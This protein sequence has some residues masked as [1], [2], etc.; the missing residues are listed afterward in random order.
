MRRDAIDRRRRRRWIAV[1]FVANVG[2]NAFLVLPSG[3]LLP[4]LFTF[5]PFFVQ[6]PKYDGNPLHPF[7]STR[8]VSNVT[9]GTQRS[10]TLVMYGLALDP[11]DQWK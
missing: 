6:I 1:R 11:T 5:E 7:S 10:P 2:L 3:I 9:K 8:E 4:T